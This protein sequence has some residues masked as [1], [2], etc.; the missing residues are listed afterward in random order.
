M[1]ERNLRLDELDSY[2]ENRDTDTSSGPSEKTTP[3]GSGGGAV[4]AS[5]SSE[6]DPTDEDSELA[7]EDT[8][9]TGEDESDEPEYDV[10]ALREE[11]ESPDLDAVEF[12]HMEMGPFPDPDEMVSLVDDQEV[13]AGTRLPDEDLIDRENGVF[14]CLEPQEVIEYIEEMQKKTDHWLNNEIKYTLQ[15]HLVGQ[16]SKYTEGLKLSHNDKRWIA[17]AEK[18]RRMESDNYEW[19]GTPDSKG[20]QPLPHAPEAPWNSDGAD[21]ASATA[22]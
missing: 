8:E 15:R 21:G 18:V 16:H 10:E 2:V 7:P 5:T 19:T 20:W 22:D 4:T 11:T 3:Q 12:D 9:D 14:L 17:R 1:T 6:S 13:T